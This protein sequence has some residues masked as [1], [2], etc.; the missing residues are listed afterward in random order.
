MRDEE[1]EIVLGLGAG[2]EMRV[3]RDDIA[4]QKA[5]KASL[6]IP[7]LDEVLGEAD[8]RD[9][10]AYLLTEPP[11]MGVYNEH[12]SPVKRTRA[13]IDAVLAD[14]PPVGELKPLKLLLVSGKKDHGIGEHDYPRWRMAWSRL[15]SLAENVSVDLAEDWPSAEQWQSADVAV[16]NRRGNWNEV[17]AEQFACFPCS[18]WRCH[19]HPLVARWR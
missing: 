5:I 16:F 1:G 14:A 10:M 4:T 13:E 18:W 11:L 12:A 8:F 7:K 9:L 19:F 17:M 6:M 2:V 3:K 15:F